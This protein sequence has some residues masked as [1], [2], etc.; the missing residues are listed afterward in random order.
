MA[1]RI[2]EQRP[3]DLRA[4]ALAGLPV[5][6]ELNWWFESI[7][8]RIMYGLIYISAVFRYLI[9]IAYHFIWYFKFIFCYSCGGSGMT[10]SSTF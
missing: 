3:I 10:L 2:P 8:M 5:A 6:G 1:L 7:W 4:Y 9:V